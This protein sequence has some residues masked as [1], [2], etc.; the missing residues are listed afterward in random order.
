MNKL[1]AVAFT[2]SAAISAAPAGEDFIFKA[3]SDELSRSMTKLQLSGHPKP[4]YVSYNVNETDSRSISGSFGAVSSEDQSHSRML[5]TDVRIGDYK[6]DSSGGSRVMDFSRMFS[7]G[8]GNSLSVDD[9]YDSLRR[10]L[11]LQ[12]DN[13]YKRAVENLKANE[14]YLKQNTVEDK[15]D[16][17]SREKPV[18]HIENT[19]HLDFDMSKW[20]AEIRKLSGIF[21]EFPNVRNSKAQVSAT[22]ANSWYLNN[23]GFKYRTGELGYT[24]YL[25]AQTQSPDGMRNSDDLIY[26]AWTEAELP[27]QDQLEHDARALAEQLDKIANAQL[28]QNYRGPVLLEGQASA[29]FFHQML[30]PKLGP[31]RSPMSQLMG[32]GDI[33]EKLGERILPKFITVVD[34]PHAKEYKG[35]TLYGTYEVDDDGIEGQKITLIDKGILKTLCMGR[36]PTRAIKQSNGH[37]KDGSPSTSNLFVTSDN[38]LGH[39]ALKARLIEL[40]KEDGLKDVYI[41]RKI[42]TAPLDFNVGIFQTIMRSMS[43]GGGGALLLPPIL[44][45]KVSTEDGHEELCRGASF[46]NVSNRILR[47][48]DVTG[49]DYKA[50]PA[51]VT[52]RIG[53]IIAP[54]VIIKEIEIQ[55]PDRTTS[56][57]P[58][59]KTL[60]SINDI[61]C[62]DP[63][64]QDLVSPHASVGSLRAKEFLYG[65]RR[66]HCY[67]QRS[68]QRLGRD[69]SLYMP[70]R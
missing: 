21:K 47:D 54:S 69:L 43:S 37:D 34:D 70:P 64:F 8:G 4:Y 60:T 39:D 61:E 46:T 42:M 68:A 67:L 38:K 24:V 56:K 58:V 30:E 6:Q 32:E 62:R 48:I 17:M 3:M 57:G 35:Q 7:G 63:L 20:S 15:P 52:K 18:V 33:D 14:T 28:Q 10:E 19:K 41:V 66:Q 23:E 45:Y 65:Q 40:G 53:S 16:S 59:L 2:M 29:E 55:K 27:S 31:T 13:G 9:N 22:C 50:Y 49:D 5:S 44:V 25:S 1:I 36:V 11:W 26:P 51:L 12:S